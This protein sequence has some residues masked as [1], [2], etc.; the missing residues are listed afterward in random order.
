MLNDPDNSDLPGKLGLAVTSVQLEVTEQGEAIFELR[1]RI[2]GTGLREDDCHHF[3][4]T[5]GNLR[6][7]VLQ[8]AKSEQLRV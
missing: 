5:G 7:R 2:D 3:G 8:R 4:R 6:S 1:N